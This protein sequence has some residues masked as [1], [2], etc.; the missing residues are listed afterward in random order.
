MSSMY[1]EG[2]GEVVLQALNRSL[3][4]AEAHDDAIRQLPLLSMLQMF[5]DRIGD[6]KKALGYAR[7][8]SVIAR[9]VEDPV[10]LALA[11]CFLGFSLHRAG[12][13]DGARAEIEAALRYGPISRETNRT[14]LGF[15][16]HCIA[17]VTLAKI[18]WLQG[19]PARAMQQVRQA[20]KDAASLDHA[21]TLSVVLIWAIVL[22]LWAGDLESAEDHVTWFV[23]RARAS[24]S[25]IYLAVGRAFEGQLAVLRGDAKYGIERL[26]DSLAD[27]HSV[28]YELLTTPF[29]ISLVQALA[30]TDQ[31]SDGMIFL[32]DETIRLVEA[33]TAIIITC[34]NCSE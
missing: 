11:H 25:G 22:F 17:S 2:Q 31:Y 20:L 8:G 5:H 3:A 26:R 27:L 1:A 23:A 15:D 28:R 10:A 24:Y 19:H 30:A 12:D 34:R 33:M 16:G 13:L 6:V 4:I 7:R 29:N 21:V 14:Q 9:T 32:I 18:L